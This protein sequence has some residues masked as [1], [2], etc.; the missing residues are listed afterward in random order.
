MSAGDSIMDMENFIRFGIVIL[1]FI[2]FVI[3]AYLYYQKATGPASSAMLFVVLLVF[4]LT[5]SN[6]KR[7]KFFGI[8]EAETWEEK[9]VQ[10]AKL[11]D[12][13][14]LLS[15]ASSQQ[16]A[17]IASKLGLLGSGLSNPQ[18]A[19]LVDNVQRILETSGTTEAERKN[20]LSPLY[21]RVALNYVQA[22]S[23]M[24]DI[25][26]RREFESSQAALSSAQQAGKDEEV[27]KVAARIRDVDEATRRLREVSFTNMIEHR[28]IQPVQNVVSG[29]A[30]LSANPVL[31]K[32]LNEIATDMNYFETNG[33]LRRNID[34]EYLY[35]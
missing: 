29:A 24:V 1:A 21:R 14:E 28:T 5:I 9:Q 22:A 16:L 10:A 25:E 17:L 19:E 6:F 31:V 18:T 3:G 2:L 34:W 32:D 7:I 13:L 26:L 11:I 8:V 15:R 33:R 12:R 20:I 27:Q 30:I 4:V 23:K 35:K